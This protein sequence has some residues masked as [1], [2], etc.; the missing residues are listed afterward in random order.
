VIAE[1][2]NFKTQ[3]TKKIQKPNEKL[4]IAAW[5][6]FVTCDLSFGASGYCSNG[7]R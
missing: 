5:D 7:S 2:T 4:K 3:I 6:F 1:I